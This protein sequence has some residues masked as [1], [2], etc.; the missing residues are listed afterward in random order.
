MRVL[1]LAVALTAASGWAQSTDAQCELSKP[2][3]GQRLLRRLS[4]DLRGYV[5]SY[6]EQL[7]QRSVADVSATKLDSYLASTDFVGQMRRYH[8][9]LLWPNLDAA[10]V[11][12]LQ[13]KLFPF[14]FGTAQS[15]DIVYFSVLRA[16][17]MR[18]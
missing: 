1:T 18:S 13:Q 11:D 3:D 5:P 2:V 16:L 4:L 8:E 14:N 12:P 17:F 9:Q 15:P 7:D 6:Q 10:E